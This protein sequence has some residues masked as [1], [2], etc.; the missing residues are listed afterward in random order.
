MYSTTAVTRAEIDEICASIATAVG[1]SA[2]ASCPPILG[3]WN[4]VKVTCM[5]L[6]TNVS[7]ATLATIFEVSQPTISRAITA[8]TPMLASIAVETIPLPE[9][10]DQNAVYVVD[11]TLLPCWSWRDH[12]QLYSG[13]HHRTGLTIQ[14][15]V[16]LAGQL[17]WASDPTP[18]SWHDIHA[19]RESGLL[20]GTDATMWLGDK[21]YIGLGIHT[22]TRKP[23]HREQTAAEKAGNTSINKI[24]WIAEQAIANLKTWRILHTDY[25]RPLETFATT[26]TAVLGLHFHR[27]AL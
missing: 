27:L 21:G 8:V 14:V 12:P 5:Y 26:I 20:D 3:L 13:K 22:P 16:T 15:A 19:L 6:R 1:A 11:G 18:G 4:S 9:E 10:L 7:E 25:R 2:A 17:A 23:A 24:R